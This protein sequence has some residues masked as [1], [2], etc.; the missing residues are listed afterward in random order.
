MGAAGQFRRLVTAPSRL[1]ALRRE[2]PELRRELAAERDRAE[3][4]RRRVRA[5]RTRIQQKDATIATQ[6]LEIERLRARAHEA[7]TTMATD[8]LPDAVV[9]RIGAVIRE[10][11]SYLKGPQ[12]A[13]LARAALDAEA[14]EIPGLFIEAGT[15]RGGSAIVLAAAKSPERRLAV[16]DVFGMIP[17]PSDADGEDVHRRYE[18]IASGGARGVGGETYYGYR[19]DLYG[20][21]TE[22][23]ARHGYPV[24]RSNV[25]LVQGYFE[26]TIRLD[27]P[28]ALAHLDGD[29]YESTRTCLERIVPHLV[30][31]GRLVVDDYFAWSGCRTAVDEYFAGRAGFRRE[32]HGRLH[33][34]RT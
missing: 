30:T 2:V 22:S 34:V 31:G 24:G 28:V 25:E 5:A 16:Y 8:T 11:L 3:D 19:D 12:L 18:K 7:E 33:I 15:A 14:Q 32:L 29:W 27:E 20:E 21:V 23:F 17:P 6:R 1:L 26:D 9:E 4:L 13:A 10:N